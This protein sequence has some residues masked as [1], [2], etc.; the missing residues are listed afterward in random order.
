MLAVLLISFSLPLTPVDIVLRAD[1]VHSHFNSAT[2]A[3]VESL[4]MENGEDRSR[5]ILDNVPL[6]TIRT[7]VWINPDSNREMLMCRVTVRLTAEQREVLRRTHTPRR[8]ILRP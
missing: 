8:V 5:T 7:E 1:G 2:H 3:D 6:V 4:Y